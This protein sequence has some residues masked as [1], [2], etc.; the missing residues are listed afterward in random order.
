MMVLADTSESDSEDENNSNNQITQEYENTKPLNIHKEEV[1]NDKTVLNLM[2]VNNTEINR[3]FY[4]PIHLKTQP[5]AKKSKIEY[6][7]RIIEKLDIVSTP[8]MVK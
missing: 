5:I 6:P 4:F 1:S 7:R 8:V 2:N 3:N